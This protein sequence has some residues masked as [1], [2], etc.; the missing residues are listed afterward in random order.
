MRKTRTRRE[1]LDKNSPHGLREAAADGDED[2]GGRALPLR[3]HILLLGHLTEGHLNDVDSELLRD[4]VEVE[5]EELDD[6]VEE[7]HDVL[8]LALSLCLDELDARATALVSPR[9]RR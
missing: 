5:L 9:I 8:A 4:V 7:E 2:D 1:Q 3:L 6:E